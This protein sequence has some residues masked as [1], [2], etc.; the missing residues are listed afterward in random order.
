MRQRRRDGKTKPLEWLKRRWKRALFI[1]SVFQFIIIYTLICISLPMVL[2]PW[3]FPSWYSINLDS[4]DDIIWFEFFNALLFILS[5]FAA[6][7]EKPK[8]GE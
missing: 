8:G 6:K 1:W 4:L 3:L 7:P 2:F 5:L